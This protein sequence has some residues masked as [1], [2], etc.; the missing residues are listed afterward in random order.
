MK[1]YTRTQQLDELQKMG[2]GS[3]LANMQVGAACIVTF[4]LIAAYVH[5]HAWFIVAGFSAIVILAARSSAPHIRYAA[6]AI[7]HGRH[8]AGTF[9]VSLDTTRDSDAWVA[10][11]RT[12]E[13]LEWQFEFVPLY[14]KPTAGRFTGQV[15][16]ID[17][18]TWPV[19]CFVGDN[20]MHPRYEPK[21]V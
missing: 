4:A 11:V 5:S 12:G 13:Q 1:R 6:K 14:W 16:F 21:L 19:L 2:T 20:V 7:R 8:I 15:I 17:D 18:V 9:D 10:L 3:L